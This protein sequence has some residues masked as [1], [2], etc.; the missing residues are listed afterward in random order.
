MK[1]KNKRDLISRRDFI[2]GTA[3]TTF[4]LALGINSFDFVSALAQ[5]NPEFPELAVVNDGSPAELTRKVLDLLGGMKRFVSKG[6]VVVVKPN[7]GWDRNPEQ[8]A[9]TNPEV[10]A[11][12][13]KLCFESG[14]KKVK[15]FDRPCNTAS[16]C[17]NRSGIQ[18][19][20]SDAGAEVSYVVDSG[21]VKTKLPEGVELKFW[22]LY[23]PALDA[24]VFINVP[25]AKHHG[26]TRV[27]LGMKN[28]MGIM[29]GN[30]GQ[31]HWNI[32]GKLADL[33][34]YVKPDLT[35][36]DAVRM[37]VRNGPQ[38]GNLKDVKKMDTI[39]AGENIATVDAYGATLFGIKPSELELIKTGN[40]LGLGEI[41][42]DKIRMKKLSLS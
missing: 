21:F 2:K 29:G 41:D 35:I 39:I 10:V 30:R 19:A 5:E 7:I 13:I 37:L 31:V 4:G 6:D 33:A 40:K 24:D 3:Y 18:K 25:I 11:E 27:T 9:N 12:V 16:R 1:E 8:A 22:W 28:L 23:K 26:L 42:L 20:A 17:Y 14:A 36:L 34:Y 15:V 38:G 32:E